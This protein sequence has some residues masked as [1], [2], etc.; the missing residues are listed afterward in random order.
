MAKK[1]LKTKKPTVEDKLREKITE[2]ETANHDGSEMLK[3][4]RTERD[5]LRAGVKVLFAFVKRA[6]MEN[7]RH[8]AV[9]EEYVVRDM[10]NRRDSMGDRYEMTSED[11]LNA[12]TCDV[13]QLVKDFAREDEGTALMQEHKDD[14]M[15]IIRGMIDDTTRPDDRR[16]RL[17]GII[18]NLELAKKN[19]FPVNLGNDNKPLH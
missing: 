9:R 19:G 17:A 13:L 7:S 16:E 8:S 5:D 6:I 1:K 4:V 10:Y 3:K 11:M 15:I 14:L 2:L 18:H 12:I